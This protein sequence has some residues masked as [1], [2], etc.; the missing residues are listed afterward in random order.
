MRQRSL[1]CLPT[2]YPRPRGRHQNREGTVYLPARRGSGARV[3]GMASTRELAL[4]VVS[5]NQAKVL[6]AWT[7]AGTRGFVSLVM[8]IQRH[9]R[10][11]RA[12]PGL[13]SMRNVVSPHRP[14]PGKRTARNADGGAG[15]GWRRK[16]RPAC[17]GPDRG[18]DDRPAAQAGRLPP[19]P[20]SRER[21]TNRRRRESR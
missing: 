12:Y 10:K 2:T 21:L 5:Q 16:Q 13:S 17:N 3:T 11:A 18:C 4:N 15:K 8:G 14:R 1:N 19:G 6:T 7:V 9:R 20:S